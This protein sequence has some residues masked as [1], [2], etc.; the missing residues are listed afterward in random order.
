VA[1]VQVL[2]VD[3]QEPFRQAAAAVIEATAGFAV[4][5]VV[6]S[7]EESL[8]AANARRIDLVLMDVNLPGIDGL[9]ASARLRE[10]ADPP[11]VV[12]VST[13]DED[14]FSDRLTEVGAV[15]YLSKSRFGSE[16]LAQV[17]DAAAGDRPDGAT[18]ARHRSADGSTAERPPAG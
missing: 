1:V 10:L 5:G 2:V 8:I 4:A 11:I 15:A 6:A 16:S 13:H 7:G 18:P 9:T 14:E 3:Y 12:L 17:W